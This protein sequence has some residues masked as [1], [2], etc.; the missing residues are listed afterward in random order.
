MKSIPFLGEY[1][2]NYMNTRTTA[3]DE[4]LDY[5]GRTPLLFWMTF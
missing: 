4:N 2:K 1:N 3:P 5:R